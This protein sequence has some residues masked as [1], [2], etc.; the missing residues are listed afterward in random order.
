MN[1]Y[2]N[3]RNKKDSVQHVDT[4]LNERANNSMRFGYIILLLAKER[5]TLTS[6]TNPCQIVQ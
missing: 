6:R 3:K 4:L 1:I 5:K 2:D